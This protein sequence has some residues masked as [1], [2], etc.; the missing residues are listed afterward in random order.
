M[1]PCQAAGKRFFPVLHPAIPSGMLSILSLSVPWMLQ[2]P[3]RKSAVRYSRL[4]HWYFSQKSGW[5]GPYFPTQPHC[6]VLCLSCRLPIQRSHSQVRSQR[7]TA[8]LPPH[9]YRSSPGRNFY[10]CNKQ[11]PVLSI[12]AGK[13]EVFRREQ[14]FLRSPLQLPVRL[15][16]R[17]KIQGL[18]RLPAHTPGSAPAGYPV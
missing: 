18:H 11:E 10:N 3:S 15:W 13:P 9:P 14:L 2:R 16:D 6:T 12:A 1:P 7:E 17:D 8:V 5:S 4:F